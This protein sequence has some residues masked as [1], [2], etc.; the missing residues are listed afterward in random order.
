MLEA[1]ISMSQDTPDRRQVARQRILR[2][3]V[4]WLPGATGPDGWHC[5]AHD[6]SPTGIGLT[7]PLYL[8]RGTELEIEA[9][10]LP[11]ARRLRARVVHSCPFEFAWMC[12]CELASPLTE[13]ELRTWQTRT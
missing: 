4:V 6:I 12:G 7:V 9:W 13:A 10:G 5:I 2:K 8:Q 3:C 11:G 1:V